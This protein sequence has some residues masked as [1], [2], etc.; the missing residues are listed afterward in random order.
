MLRLKEFRVQRVE[1]RET[2]LSG[3]TA[4]YNITLLSLSNVVSAFPAQPLP[5]CISAG[6]E[7]QDV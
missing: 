7:I 5:E 4:Y 1:F 6:G 2:L 3:F